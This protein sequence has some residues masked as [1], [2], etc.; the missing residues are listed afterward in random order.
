MLVVCTIPANASTSNSKGSVEISCDSVKYS[1]ERVKEDSTAIYF[2]GSLN[3]GCT[4]DYIYVSALGSKGN[5]NNWQNKTYVDGREVKYVL[6][7]KDLPYSIST[8]IYED[9]AQSYTAKAKL[10]FKRIPKNSGDYAS[11]KLNYE[12]SPDSSGSYYPAT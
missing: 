4:D 7:R 2:K 11:K 10:L 3:K 9:L 1:G 12:W 8:L 6:C 5:E